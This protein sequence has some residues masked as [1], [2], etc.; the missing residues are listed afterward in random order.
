MQKKLKSIVDV[1][2]GHQFRGKVVPD[3]EGDV[4]VIQIKDMDERR[5][6]DT[7]E[8]TS[9][10][11]ENA[12]RYVVWPGDVLFL[13]RGHRMYGTVVPELT[14]KTVTSSYFFILRPKSDNVLPRYLAWYLNEPDFQNQLRPFI[15]GSRMPLISRTDF[16]DLTV[17]LPNLETQ[18]EIVRLN[19]LM[20]NEARLMDQLK[21]KRAT[22]IEGVSRN[23]LTGRLKNKD[24]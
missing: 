10:K 1:R 19:E 11:L 5:E 4:D 15:R 7:R 18:Q 17:M 9:V 22:L 21:A 16:P 20:L 8:L 13:S 12:D 2:T 24:Q 6:V 23:L 14:R 3:D